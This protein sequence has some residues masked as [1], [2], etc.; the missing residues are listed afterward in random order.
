MERQID[1]AEAMHM[2]EQMAQSTIHQ[3]MKRCDNEL[4]SI[5]MDKVLD[6]VKILEICRHYGA[7]A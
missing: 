3:I 6:A 1:Q 7:K 5:D 4:D 2:A